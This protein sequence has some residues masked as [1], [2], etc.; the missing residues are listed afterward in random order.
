MVGWVGK[1]YKW[2]K[3]TE[4]P[5]KKIDKL[6]KELDYVDTKKFTDDDVKLGPLWKKT[7][8]GAKVLAGGTAGMVAYDKI[9]KKFKKKKDKDKD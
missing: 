1:V 5:I 6:V 3:K 9:K 8:T 4:S 7:K 2:A